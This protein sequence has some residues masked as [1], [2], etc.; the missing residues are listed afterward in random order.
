MS[1]AQMLRR[2]QSRHESHREILATAQ[3]TLAENPLRGSWMNPSQYFAQV[4][5]E[6]VLDVRCRLPRGRKWP[7]AQRSS[8][9]VGRFEPDFADLFCL[10]AGDCSDVGQRVRAESRLTTP[11]I[12]VVATRTLRMVA[13]ESLS[14]L[15]LAHVR[16]TSAGVIGSRSVHARQQVYQQVRRS[17]ENLEQS[18]CV[19]FQTLTRAAC[20]MAS[21]SQQQA[22]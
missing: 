14:Q 8:N 22:T 4:P 9:G 13:L 2:H 17:P 11:R 10:A 21:S 12:L 3:V 15:W 18:R 16:M 5:W 19:S 7:G 6:C 20:K 1:M